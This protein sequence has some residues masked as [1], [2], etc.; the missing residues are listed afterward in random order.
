MIVFKYA[1]DTQSFL[2]N[3]LKLLRSFII[4]NKYQLS[5]VSEPSYALF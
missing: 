3:L 5:D 2:K 4:K 1:P